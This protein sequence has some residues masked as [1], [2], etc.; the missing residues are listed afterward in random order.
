MT[1]KLMYHCPYFEDCSVNRRIFENSTQEKQIFFSDP[2][3]VCRLK[4]L[5]RIS[6]IRKMINRAKNDMLQETS[7]DN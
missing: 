1:D 6:Y 2:E 5:H 3:K 7:H 4:K